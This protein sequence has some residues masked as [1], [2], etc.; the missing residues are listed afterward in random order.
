MRMFWCFKLDQ[1]L[2]SRAV[3]YEISWS[4][5]DQQAKVLWWAHLEFL[6]ITS[7][8]LPK[9]LYG[10]LRSVCER[11]TIDIREATVCDRLGRDVASS[12]KG[13]GHDLH[14]RNVANVSKYVF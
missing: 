6:I 8:P 13:R 9:K 11:G 7:R 5:A 14:F 4:C 12:F 10:H 3:R 2:S 1:V